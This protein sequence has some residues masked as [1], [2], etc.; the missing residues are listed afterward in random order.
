[1][2]CKS[3]AYRGL[4]LLLALLLLGGAGGQ[5]ARAEAANSLGAAPAPVRIGLTLGL[6]GRY[7]PMAEHQRQGFELWVRDINNR[8]GLLG[9]P[10][11]LT[12]VDDRSRI[13]EAVA[14]YR[15][16]IEDER[17]DLLFAP[18]SSEIT[19]AVLPHTE[20]HRYPLLAS[21]AASDQIWE[22]GYRYVFGL[23]TPAS[24]FTFS[25]LEMLL[26][27]SLD[28]LA[29]FHSQEPLSRSAAQ[30]SA[31]WARWL[32]LE[33]SL[34]Q[35]FDRDQADYAEL[36]AAARQSGAEVV[37]MAGH[38]NEAVAMRR[39]MAAAD[40]WPRVYY[41]IQGP[42]NEAFVQ[43]LGAAANGVF[44][45]EQWQYLAGM[46]ADERSGWFV[47]TYKEDY[48]VFPH[49]FAFTAYAAGSILATA[50][51]KAGSLERERIRDVLARLDIQCITGRFRVDESGRQT[52]NFTLVTQRQNGRLE[53]V[54]PLS[55]QTAG[56]IL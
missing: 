51:E 3:A 19:M 49:Y 13:E 53:V 41:A 50:V 36:V 10:V 12:I 1:M 2:P 29:I 34:I 39:A 40:W 35:E 7:A 43:Q 15:R 45:T 42:G 28:N 14:G 32:G 24:K 6:S 55:L 22:Q 26:F 25:L 5:P 47:Q 8:G 46:V 33:L 23:F 9:R 27:Y 30:G 17:K 54:W 56:P 52:R 11:E 18:F 38:I 16:F 21:G 20:E 44:G 48:G 37:I 31:R 4:G